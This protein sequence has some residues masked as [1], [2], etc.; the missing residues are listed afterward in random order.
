MSDD[1]PNKLNRI[2]LRKDIRS[3]I[4]DN[5]Q[6]AKEYFGDLKYFFPVRKELSAE[7]KRFEVSMGLFEQQITSFRRKPPLFRSR[8]ISQFKKLFDRDIVVTP[9]Y[10]EDILDK[11]G[12]VL[13]KKGSPNMDITIMQELGKSKDQNIFK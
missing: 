5:I 6:G 11:D 10:P 9:T 8:A 7:E 2:E 13:Y 12:K 1:D 3:F 4:K